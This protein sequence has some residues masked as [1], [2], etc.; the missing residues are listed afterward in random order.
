MKPEHEIWS[1]KARINGDRND[2]EIDWPNA[3]NLGPDRFSV[4]V[5]ADDIDGDGPFVG[6]LTVEKVGGEW[7]WFVGDW[8]PEVAT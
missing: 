1:L 5:R 6:N 8:G 2:I 4:P 7:D 3:R